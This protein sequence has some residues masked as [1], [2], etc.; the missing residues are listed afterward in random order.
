V[1]A[2]T[3]VILSACLAVAL[4]PA[5]AAV[6]GSAGRP[7]AVTSRVGSAATVPVG[8]AAPAARAGS[9]RPAALAWKPCSEDRS[10]Q[11]ATLRVPIDWSH[12]YGSGVD[13]ALA[14]R[15]ATDPAARIGALVVNPGGPGG[16]GVDFALGGDRF[17]SAGLRRRFDIVGFD[18]RGVA[19]SHP[20]VCSAAVSGAAPSP[21][22]TSAADFTAMIA[23]N[24]RLA[25]DCRRHTGPLFDHVDT[26]SVVHDIEALRAALGEERLSFYGASYGTL[27]GQQYAELYPDKVRAI[28]LDSTIDHS[29]G[30]ADFLTVETDAVQDSFDEFAAWCARDDLCLLRGRDVRAIWSTLLSRAGRGVLRDPVDPAYRLTVLD[31]LDLGFSSFYEPQWYALAYYLDAADTG[32]KGRRPAGRAAVA[33]V[34]AAGRASRVGRRTGG[35]WAV[36]LP[37]PAANRAGSPALVENTFS[38]IFCEDWAL[39]VRD[40]DAFAGE[41]RRLARRAPQMRVSPLA[42]TGVVGCLGWPSTPD[43]PQRRLGPVR[44]GPLLLINARHDPATAYRWAQGAAS[45]L[46]TAAALVPYDGWGHA[47]YG[48]GACGTS[49]VD[50]YLTALWTPPPGAQC[51][52]VPPDPFG[53]DGRSAVPTAAPRPG[54]RGWRPIT[55]GE[56]T[57]PVV[58]TGNRR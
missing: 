19:R 26:L 16:S 47:V 55:G 7:A 12:P 27:M 5:G 39:P 58:S 9:A 32:T 52:A 46:G 28:G 15:P 21:L 50:R 29:V 57:S 53:V 33:R 34:A 20:V 4:V 48:R 49:V 40:Y 30:T 56:P 22:L 24:R 1:R 37:R 23:Y 8:P 2:T 35:A 6:P 14:R 18:P 44:T 38:A 10:V 42:L 17:F 51:P 31:L 41:L 13:V 11:C 3:R 45:Q 43:N 25:A 36:E 54:V